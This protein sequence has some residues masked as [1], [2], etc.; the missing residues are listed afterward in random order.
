MRGNKF[1]F[2]VGQMPMIRHGANWNSF[3][4]INWDDKI[5]TQFLIYY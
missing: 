2:E 3:L 4:E 1:D 5:L